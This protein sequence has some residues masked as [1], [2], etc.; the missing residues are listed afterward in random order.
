MCSFSSRCLLSSLVAAACSFAVLAL[1]TP[2]AHAQASLTFSGG[3]G[4]PLT[5][6][7]ASSVS[8]TVTATVDTNLAP[9]FLFKNIPNVP[10]GY[11]ASGSSTITFRI[12][13]GTSQSIN[14]F[15]SGVSTSGEV[16][17]ND[18]L[19]LG[20]L[21]GVT[22]GDIVTL[23]SGTLTTNINAETRPANGSY[24]TYLVRGNDF[25]R[26]SANGVAVAAPEAGSASLILGGSVAFLSMVVLRKQRAVLSTT[27]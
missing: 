21:P 14:T 24:E 9:Y 23:A 20:Q 12:N 18:I 4:T 13:G 6:N 25:T 19:L 11:G 3:N 17:R 8:Y 1:A 7:L 27:R 10:L 5:L 26:I 22:V 16:G 2:R 15:F